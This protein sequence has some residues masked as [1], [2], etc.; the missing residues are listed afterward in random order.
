MMELRSGVDLAIEEVPLGDGSNRVVAVA[1]LRG[2][3]KGESVADAFSALDEQVLSRGGRGLV[4]DL[5]QVSTVLSAGLAFIIEIADRMLAAGSRLGIVVTPGSNLERL[6]T[7][8]DLQSVSDVAH[9][10]DE[11]LARRPGGGA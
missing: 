9:G 5:T 6:L 7:I 11:L 8:T 1:R 4:L 2:S 3:L 10:L